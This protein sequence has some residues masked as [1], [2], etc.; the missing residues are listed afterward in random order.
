M[1]TYEQNQLITDVSPGTPLNKYWKKFWLPVLRSAALD[2]GAAPKKV[3]MLC[4]KYVAFRGENGKVGFLYEACP[5]R[6]VSLAMGRNENNSLT[7]IFH[8]WRFDAEGNCINMPTE[9]DQSFCNKVKGQGFPVKEAG[10]MVW[11]YLGEGEPPKFSDYAFNLMD[12]DHVRPRA[13]YNEANWLQNVETLLDS[14]HINLLHSDTTD[15]SKIPQ[16]GLQLT[17]GNNTPQYTFEPRPYGLRSYSLRDNPNAELNNLRVTEYVA[18]G[19]AFIGT[20]DDEAG[21]AIIVLPVNNTRSLQWYIYWD[22]RQP[23]NNNL[24]DFAIDGT[25]PDDDNF[26]ASR[27]GTYM[28]GQDRAAMK[29]GES[30]SGIPGVIFED[31]AVA[32]SIPVVDRTREFLGSGDLAI[33]RMRRILM[34]RIK[35]AQDD[36]ECV[37]ADE[38]DYKSLRALAD[39]IPKDTDIKQHTYAKE[40]ARKADFK[41]EHAA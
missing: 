5:H 16:Y 25:D 23:I 21:F 12:A 13:S 9:K 35:L 15:N 8:G 22:A 39:M 28:Y 40:A 11:V 33:V 20:T 30:W 36:K 41:D 2:V 4:E 1:L 6:G 27:Q 19:T 32:E 26:A 37:F 10:G 17:A 3:E 24:P 34:E 29:A 31:Y 14:A 7:C 38:C 18:P